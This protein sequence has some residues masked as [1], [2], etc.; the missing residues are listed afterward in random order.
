MPKRFTSIPS[1]KK[2]R[3]SSGVNKLR[4]EHHEISRKMK[5]KIDQFPS[6]SNPTT[7]TPRTKYISPQK[8]LLPEILRL[9]VFYQLLCI[10]T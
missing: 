3:Q 1:N 8:N 2:E 7:R 6:I 4:I 9:T 10:L 5:W